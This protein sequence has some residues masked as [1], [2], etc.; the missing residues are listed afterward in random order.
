MIEQMIQG[1]T[2]TKE[3]S[4]Y[5]ERLSNMLA[6]DGCTDIGWFQVVVPARKTEMRGEF[7]KLDGSS[8]LACI[9]CLDMTLP[10]NSHVV[11]TA[12]RGW[13]TI[14]NAFCWGRD[15]RG[16]SMF[17]YDR[18]CRDFYATCKSCWKTSQD[19]ENNVQI[20]GY[21]KD[22][23][24]IS[25]SAQRIY[26]TIY[27]LIVV[28]HK[29]LYLY[30]RFA[31]GLPN[32]PSGAAAWGM[33][34]DSYLSE[35]YFALVESRT[36]TAKKLKDE[37]ERVSP[38]LAAAARYTIRIG[39][40]KYDCVEMTEK[41]LEMSDDQRKVLRCYPSMHYVHLKQFGSG[42]KSDVI[43]WRDEDLR[44]L[45]SIQLE[46]S[47]YSY[48][49]QEADNRYRQELEEYEERMRRFNPFGS[50]IS[51]LQPPI[52]PCN[53]RPRESMRLKVGKEL[54]WPTGKDVGI[55][56]IN[57]VARQFLRQRELLL[58]DAQDFQRKKVEIATRMNEESILTCDQLS[59]R[60]KLDKYKDA[61]QF[62]ITRLPALESIKY[63]KLDT[64]LKTHCGMLVSSRTRDAF[65]NAWSKLVAARK[66][67][68]HGAAGE[69][70]VETTLKLVDDQL[71]YL[72][73]VTLKQEFEC[74]HDFI[75]V[76]SSGIFTI[77][78]K[79]LS[80]NY[81]LTPAG[82]LMESSGQSKSLTFNIG[83]QINLHVQTLRRVLAKC[84]A[85][86]A[87]VP[88][89]GIM[90]FAGDKCF[91]DDKYERIPTCYANAVID[92][93]LQVDESK[94]ILTRNDMEQITEY[95]E[96]NKIPVRKYDVFGDHGDL[97]DRDKFMD[98]IV[99]VLAGCQKQKD[100]LKRLQTA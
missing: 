32:G 2:H 71:L 8:L 94:E 33:P 21:L 50:D 72:P 24:P 58:E 75:I 13:H 87:R 37:L 46:R 5:Y 80:G 91:V 25:S 30:E 64:W 9:D 78:V 51:L 62:C 28:D 100:I 93:V 60:E 69:R 55:E 88:I 20:E 66:K 17:E 47:V 22:F 98:S 53:N 3:A 85:M 12:H 99:S 42:S 67:F 7:G 48:K 16:N 56:N 79:T 4:E 59:M 29:P 83:A 82:Y 97:G 65:K 10:D 74:E 70:A 96:K 26:E 15:E 19:G 81:T 61:E 45:E 34:T 36:E 68:D 73:S 35:F 18:H 38:E 44:I 57:D 92:Q 31:I 23:M 39:E 77:E 14:Y 84:P 43:V 40:S 76:T 41:V 95:L 27:R 63:D 52:A 1:G 90:C 86:N 54:S 49:C 89:T 6:A 11:M